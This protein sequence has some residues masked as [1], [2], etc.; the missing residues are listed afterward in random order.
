MEVKAI[1]FEIT[2]F[3][4][5]IGIQIY[6]QNISRMQP[7]WLPATAVALALGAV[8]RHLAY[9]R[10]FPEGLTAVKTQQTSMSAK[11][12]VGIGHSLA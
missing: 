8:L 7:L 12:K 4:V 2:C 6:F 3:Q 1:Y 11:N 5:K 9:G 10:G